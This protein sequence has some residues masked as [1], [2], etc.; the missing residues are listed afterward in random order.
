MWHASAVFIVFNTIVGFYFAVF[1]IIVLNV[2]AVFS[3]FSFDYSLYP[4]GGRSVGG[5]ARV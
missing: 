2:F 3:I 4:V 5:A 1:R